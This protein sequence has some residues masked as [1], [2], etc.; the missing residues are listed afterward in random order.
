MNRPLVVVTIRIRVLVAVRIGPEPALIRERV[1]E[2]A[3]TERHLGGE[4][5]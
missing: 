2:G 5:L 3:G 4:V 1:L